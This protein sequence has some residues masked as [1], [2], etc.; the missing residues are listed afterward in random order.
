MHS[1]ATEALG[2]VPMRNEY[3]MEAMSTGGES[4]IALYSLLIRISSVGEAFLRALKKMDFVLLTE[5]HFLIASIGM[6]LVCKV[7]KRS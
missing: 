1:V 4:Q 3:R 5:V 6:R 7:T 2:D